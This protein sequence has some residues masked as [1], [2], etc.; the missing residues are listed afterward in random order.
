LRR[1][2]PRPPR[3]KRP[4]LLKRKR[5]LSN[6]RLVVLGAISGAFGVRGEVRIR[7]F[8][9]PPENIGDYGELITDPG[10]RTL[11]ILGLRPATK[12]FAARIEGIND[13]DAA[14]GL[15]GLNLCVP[16][17]ALPEADEDEFYHVD[18]VGCRAV[19]QSGEAL[20]QVIAVQDFGA[21]PLLEV[22]E[23][24]STRFYPFTGDAVP[25]VDIKAKRV[26]V[27]DSAVAAEREDER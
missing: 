9:E 18:L 27:A 21:G 5:R 3:L 15:R 13:R 17:E 23:N 12:G 7:S 25:E 16:R 22:G 11:K 6:D 10:G 14:D 26:V 19:S 8:T 2:P 24:G 4:P 20:G 1:L